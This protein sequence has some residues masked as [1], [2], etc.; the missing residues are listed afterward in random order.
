MNPKCLLIKTVFLFF[1]PSF[2]NFFFSSSWCCVHRRDAFQRCQKKW[3]IPTSNPKNLHLRVESSRQWFRDRLASLW[4][5]QKYSW[6]LIFFKGRPCECNMSFDLW[7]HTSSPSSSSPFI[8]PSSPSSTLSRWR[9]PR[10]W[11]PVRVCSPPAASV[12][13]RCCSRSTR[14]DW[15]SCRWRCLRLRPGWSSVPSSACPCAPGSPGSPDCGAWRRRRAGPGWAGCGG[16][17]TDACGG[18]IY[19]EARHLVE[20]DLIVKSSTYVHFFMHFPSLTARWCCCHI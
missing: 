12:S 11:R 9:S 10:S 6:L 20:E 5:H 7:P 17:G 19:P 14:S 2:S 1:F 8:I 4:H 15:S 16:S 18:W 13:P 3:E